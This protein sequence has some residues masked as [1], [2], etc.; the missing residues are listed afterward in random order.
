DEGPL[1]EAW[2]SLREQ[3]PEIRLIIAPHEPTPAHLEP[4]ERWANRSELRCARLGS[5]EAAE[6]DVVVV[7]RVGVLGDLYAIAD[8]AYVGGGFHAAGPHPGLEPRGL[9]PPLILRA[10]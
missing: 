3:H 6:A 4:I 2:S 7:D 10:C 1:L 8:I 5:G 9:G